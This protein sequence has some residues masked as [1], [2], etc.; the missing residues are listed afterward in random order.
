MDGWTLTYIRST[1]TQCCHP[2][3]PSAAQRCTKFSTTRREQ[4]TWLALQYKRTWSQWADCAWM[5]TGLDIQHSTTIHN[6]TTPTSMKNELLSA[7]NSRRVGTFMKVGEGKEAPRT[8]CRRSRGWCP[9]RGC[10]QLTKNLGPSWAPPVESRVK[11]PSKNEFGV[12]Y[13]CQKAA[14]SKDSADFIAQVL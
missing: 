5:R 7:L 6:D 10:P 8:W 2:A 11:D 3:T 4:S 1:A 14:G 9:G 12:C 13:A